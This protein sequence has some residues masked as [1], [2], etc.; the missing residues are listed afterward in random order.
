MDSGERA[1]AEGG[2]H[3]GRHRGVSLVR[4]F[5][6][7]AVDAG[8]EPI[9]NCLEPGRK[10]RIITSRTSQI[11]QQGVLT[12]F[13]LSVTGGIGGSLGSAGKDVR[14]TEIIAEDFY[15]FSTKS[16]EGYQQAQQEDSHG[17]ALSGCLRRWRSSARAGISD[18]AT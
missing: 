4:V 7:I 18:P 16:A 8:A 6:Q 12:V 14:S 15:G 3:R 13:R 10:Q 2:D 1:A 17:A 5:C 11:A 9:D